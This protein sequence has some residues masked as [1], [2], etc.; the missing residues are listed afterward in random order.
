ML[1]LEIALCFLYEESCFVPYVGI[2][3]GAIWTDMHVTYC[4]ILA[5]LKALTLPSVKAYSDDASII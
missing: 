2:G 3:M 4:N 1:L 5:S